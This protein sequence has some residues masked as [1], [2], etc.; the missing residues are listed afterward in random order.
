M[1]TITRPPARPCARRASTKDLTEGRGPSEE[2][3]RPSAFFK[4]FYGVLGLLEP[5]PG[6]GP[7]RPLLNEVAASPSQREGDQLA[8]VGEHHHSP[9]T[10]L[11]LLHDPRNAPPEEGDGYMGSDERRASR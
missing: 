2:E 1:D 9:A 4:G 10:V 11:D 5:E 8:L 3:R 7:V 6:T